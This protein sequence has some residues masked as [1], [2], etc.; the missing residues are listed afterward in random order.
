MKARELAIHNNNKKNI[1]I[2]NP[3]KYNLSEGNSYYNEGINTLNQ[4][5]ERNQEKTVSVNLANYK[6]LSFDSNSQPDI[7][8]TNSGLKTCAKKIHGTVFINCGS[9]IKGKNYGQI[10]KVTL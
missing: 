10:A 4:N 6:H 7:I 1:L 3:N 9:F 8:L 2:N 5:Y